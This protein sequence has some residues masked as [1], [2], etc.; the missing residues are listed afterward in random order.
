[1]CGGGPHIDPLKNAV[2]K[3]NR[4]I[5]PSKHTPDHRVHGHV[6]AYMTGSSKK[7]TIPEHRNTR[8]DQAC[9]LHSK[10]SDSVFGNLDIRRISIS[11]TVSGPEVA[12]GWCKD[13]LNRLLFCLGN[14]RISHSSAYSGISGPRPLTRSYRP[15]T[16]SSSAWTKIAMV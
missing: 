15:P 9:E 7:I 8:H 10:M 11:R 14:R 2:N 16:S 13:A 5:R 6:D 3:E 12:A 1:M 4:H